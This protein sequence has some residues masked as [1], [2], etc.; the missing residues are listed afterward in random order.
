NSTGIVTAAYHGR[1]QFL[2]V[3]LGRD[4]WGTFDPSSQLIDMHEQQE[5]GDEDL[6]NLAAVYTLSHK[7]TVYAVAPEKVP[8]GVPMAAIFWLPLRERTSKKAVG[9]SLALD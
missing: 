3:A 6:V 2:F 9:S 5:P 8:G 1:I 7:G 4:Q